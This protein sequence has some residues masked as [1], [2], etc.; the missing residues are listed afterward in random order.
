MVVQIIIARCSPLLKPL[1]MDPLTVLGA[2]AAASQFIAYGIKLTKSISQFY[3]FYSKVYNAPGSICKKTI[4][5]EQ[6]IDLAR[7]IIQ[8]PSLQKESVASILRTCLTG[9]EEIQRILEKVSVT[10]KDGKIKR[11][12]KALAATVKEKDIIALFNNLEREKSSL[13]LCIQG[14][15]SQ[16]LWKSLAYFY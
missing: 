2:A 12:L 13:A 8:N 9:A 16:V 1:A 14:I 4:Q 3:S 6:L 10:D 5:V 7:L 11:I 15:D